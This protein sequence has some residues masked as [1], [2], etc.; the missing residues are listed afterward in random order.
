MTRIH[1]AVDNIEKPGILVRLSG[2]DTSQ[3]ISANRS[4]WTSIPSLVSW[5]WDSDGTIIA[6]DEARRIA[7]NWGATL[8]D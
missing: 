6:E 4:V 1:Y 8:P 3:T 7:D 2:A 5:I